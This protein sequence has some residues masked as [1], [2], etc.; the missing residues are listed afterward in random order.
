MHGRRAV[1]W[2]PPKWGN[3]GGP[4]PAE[5]PSGQMQGGDGDDDLD[6]GASAADA[7]MEDAYWANQEDSM[8]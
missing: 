3:V 2:P 7:L 1:W 5:R 4:P 8:H 6:P